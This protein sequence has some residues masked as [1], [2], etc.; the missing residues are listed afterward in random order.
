MMNKANVW[1]GTVSALAMAALIGMAGA[2]APA[3]AADEKKV[4]DQTWVKIC[5]KMPEG[6]PKL[7]V[8][9]SDYIDRAKGIPYA[10]IAIENIDGKDGKKENVVVTL[11]HVWIIPAKAKNN[12]TNEE[13]D[14]VVPVSARWNILS[15]VI[16]KVD[17][18]KQHELKFVYCDQFGCTAQA[19]A[20]KELIDEMKAGKNILVAG[21]SNGQD[22]P[23][24]FVLAGFGPA[25]DGAP[26]DEE[27]Y[28]KN[29]TAKLQAIAQAQQEMF[30]K[31][32][33]EAAKAAGA[34]KPADKK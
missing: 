2:L 18:K 23:L 16:V 4:D 13:K 31:Q 15:G 9:R 21:K 33:E 34:A 6:A 1:G 24:T 30:K 7:C 32:Q 3:Q 10:P 17:D 26:T 22:L 5:P 11:P 20:P 25:Y 8:T 27:Q 12:K 19:E 28:K 14:V 29:V